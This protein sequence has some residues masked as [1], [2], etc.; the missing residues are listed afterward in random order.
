MVFLVS[1]KYV[2]IIFKKCLMYHFNFSE[3]SR[4]VVRMAGKT[5]HKHGGDYIAFHQLNT[6]IHIGKS[7]FNL[8]NLF[9][10]DSILNEVGNQFVNENS[11]L[12]LAEVIPGLEKSLSKIFLDIVNAVLKDVTFDEMF[13]NN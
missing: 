11:D 5:V 7:K 4:A 13:P 12:F 1:G 6:K 9:N 8:M 10:E 3:N 2:Y